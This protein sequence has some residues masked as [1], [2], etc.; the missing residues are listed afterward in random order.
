MENTMSSLCRVPVELVG[1]SGLL[2]TAILPVEWLQMFP[3]YL[4]FLPQPQHY[5][6]Y[7]NLCPRY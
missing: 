5:R 3:T 6:F 4:L 2:S 7:I 1:G